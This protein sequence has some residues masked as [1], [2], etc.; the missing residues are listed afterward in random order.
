MLDTG[1]GLP[2]RNLLLATTLSVIVI[3]LLLSPTLAPLAR[4]LG[5]NSE[6]GE[7]EQRQLR[8]ALA[9][10]ALQRLGELSEDATEF[11]DDLP[12]AMVEELRDAYEQQMKSLSQGGEQSRGDEALRRRLLLEIIHAQQ[13]ELVRWRDARTVSDSVIRSLQHELDLQ[14]TSIKARS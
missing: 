10:A 4:R 12:Q 9:A 11:E 7:G 14:R 3:T 2:D 6:E 8:Q 13:E 1:V 5:L